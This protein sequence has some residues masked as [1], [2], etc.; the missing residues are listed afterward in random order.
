[1][2]VRTTRFKMKQNAMSQVREI[3]EGT[4]GQV[5]KMEGMQ[6]S[7]CCVDDSG[8]GLLVAVWESEEKAKAGGPQAK[9]VWA[10]IAE[11]LDGEP[12]VTEYR[13]VVAVK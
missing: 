8:N 5:S 10:S 3:A 6:K 4:K 11:H 1:M 12:Q 2:F 9:A 7:Y 13:T